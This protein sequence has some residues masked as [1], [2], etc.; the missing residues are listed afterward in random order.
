MFCRPSDRDGYLGPNYRRSW[1]AAFPHLKD[2]IDRL[3][4][5]GDWRRVDEVRCTRWSEGHAALIGDSAHAMAPTLGQG[6]C[7]SMASAVALAGALESSDDVEAQLRRW[8]AS[9]R[10]V[11]DATQRYGRMY[12]RLMTRW[13]RP[14]LDVRSALVKYMTRSPALQARLNGRPTES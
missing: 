13:P 11:I 12:I 4:D 7:I 10:P 6:A 2:V 9:Q 8:E 1:I 14:I 5:D 3:S